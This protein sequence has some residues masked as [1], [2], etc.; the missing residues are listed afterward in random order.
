MSISIEVIAAFFITFIITLA[1]LL[2]GIVY[3]LAQYA[4]LA[5]QVGA[6]IPPTVLPQIADILRAVPDLAQKGAALT[7]NKL[8]DR[9]AELAGKPLHEIARNLTD[10]QAVIYPSDSTTI[11]SPPDKASE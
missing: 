10:L 5:K 8:D 4:D 3:I 6:L 7:P 2:A 1:G 9:I 11:T